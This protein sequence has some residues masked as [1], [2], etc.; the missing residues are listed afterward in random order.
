MHA[1]SRVIGRPP[2]GVS[3]QWPVVVS[4][5]MRHATDASLSSWFLKA[6]GLPCSTTTAESW[7]QSPTVL[8][9]NELRRPDEDAP[10]ALNL[11]RDSPWFCYPQPLSQS[12]QDQRPHVQWRPC[13][14]HMK[15][16]RRNAITM[17]YWTLTDP[18]CGIILNK[19]YNILWQFML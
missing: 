18:R 16:S 9:A 2:H 10:I 12:G 19:Y 17:L 1:G 13:T 6:A 15:I 5:G 11:N 8:T 3:R 4:Y 14:G 7:F